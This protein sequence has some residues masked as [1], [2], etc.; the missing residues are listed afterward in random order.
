MKDYILTSRDYMKAS[1]HPKKRSIP[2][3]QSIISALKR[4]FAM[5]VGGQP[6]H[7]IEGDG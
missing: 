7:V 2:T 1:F 6:R 5:N 3:N 4:L